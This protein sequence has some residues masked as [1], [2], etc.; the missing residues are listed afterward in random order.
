MTWRDIIDYA[1][2]EVGLAP[3]EFWNMTLT[4]IEIACKGY[5]VREARRKEL[6]RFIAAI[7]LNVYSRGDKKVSPES[8]M[9]LVTDNINKA[10]LMSK[11]EYE[12]MIKFF[13]SVRWN[14]AR[15]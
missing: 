15:D 12:E 7:L 2:G 6:V 5:Q 8:I 13:E 11:D 9:P 10:E 1:C 4:E 14:E 3:T